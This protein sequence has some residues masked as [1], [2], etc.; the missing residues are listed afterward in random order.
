MSN[1]FKRAARSDQ[2]ANT[3]QMGKAFW[4]FNIFLLLQSSCKP[5]ARVAPEV[6]LEGG[7]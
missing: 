4:F 5:S 2:K 6:L 3:A 1:E 7:R